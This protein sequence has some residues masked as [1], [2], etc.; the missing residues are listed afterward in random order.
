VLAGKLG[1][2]VLTD[3]VTYTTQNFFRFPRD[4]IARPPEFV[5]DSDD[6]SDWIGPIENQPLTFR[7]TSQDQGITLVPY[8]KLFGERYAVY[9]RVYRRDSEEHRCALAEQEAQAK[10]RAR[11]VDEVAIGERESEREHRMKGERTGSGSHLGHN[12]RHATDG[13][14]FS[15]EMKVLP[16]RPMVLWCRYWGDESGKRT[17]DVFVDDEKIATQ[18]LLHDKPGE[19]FEVE[20]PIPPELTRGRQTITVRFQGRPGNFAGGV[21]GCE[22]LKGE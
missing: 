11:R 12:W 8:H 13:A 7:A 2:D 17:F 21:F 9:W 19:F 10:R 18:A 16:D 22:I 6:V 5:V 15:Y 4:K 20:Y 14:W 1:G 3:E